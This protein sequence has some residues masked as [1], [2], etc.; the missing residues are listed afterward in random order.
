VTQIFIAL[1]GLG[2]IWM[3]LDPDKRLHK[4]APLVGLA[5][6]PFWAAFAWETQGWGLAALVV[7]YTAVYAR[8][9]WVQWEARRW[10]WRKFGT[11]SETQCHGCGREMTRDEAFHY[12]THCER[13]EGLYMQAMEDAA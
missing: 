4:W 11:P 6:Q 3:A 2:A 10:L 7:A 5:G 1:F 13:C 12:V 9:A 8:G